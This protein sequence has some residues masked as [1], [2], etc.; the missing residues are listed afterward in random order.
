MAA[1]WNKKDTEQF[2]RLCKKKLK[3]ILLVDF[4]MT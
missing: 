1:L 3:G 4:L 2:F